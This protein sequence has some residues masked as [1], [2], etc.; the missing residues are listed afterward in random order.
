MIRS[1]S[2]RGKRSCTQDA[3][4]RPAA[5]SASASGALAG[6]APAASRRPPHGG[7][8]GAPPPDARCECGT[9]PRGGRGSAGPGTSSTPRPGPARRWRGTSIHQRGDEIQTAITQAGVE[10]SSRVCTIG[11]ATG[12]VDLNVFEVITHIEAR[13]AN[14]PT[15]SA[16][17]RSYT[18][19]LCTGTLTTDSRT[20]WTLTDPGTVSEYPASTRNFNRCPILS[21]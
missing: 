12:G 10:A 7:G 21:L 1:A 8:R 13:A 9:A 15:Y 20:G 11:S 2:L 3:T 19:F 5:G 18:V 4:S 17:F 16:G 14:L 6:D